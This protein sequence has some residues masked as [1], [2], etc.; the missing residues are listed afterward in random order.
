MRT[1]TFYF[2]DKKSP[3][4]NQ[5]LDII[6]DAKNFGFSTIKL[7]TQNN[8]FN[9]REMDFLSQIEG[10][11]YFLELV[12]PDHFEF[13]KHID[14]IKKYNLIN[15]FFEYF[16]VGDDGSFVDRINQRKKILFDIGAKIGILYTIT[17]QNISKA[18][19][20]TKI[21]KKSNPNFISFREKIMTE[22]N[23]NCGLIVGIDDLKRFLPVVKNALKSPNLRME[24]NYQEN[25]FYDFISGKELIIES[26]GD[27]RVFPFS[28]AV[29]TA[30]IFVDNFE[31]I[32]DRL[33][34]AYNLLIKEALTDNKFPNWNWYASKYFL[35]R[36]S[37]A[38][39]NNK[40]EW[41]DIENIILPMA[42]N[43]LLTRNCNLQCDFCEFECGEDK[44]EFLDI[45]ILEKLLTDGKKLGISSVVFD[46]GEPLVYPEIRK[47]LDL[48]R[49]LDYELVMLTNGWY[50]KEFEKLLKKCKINDLIFNLNGATAS[51]HDKIV[52]KDG[53]YEK[54]IQSIKQ[55]KVQGFPVSIL[56]LLHPLNLNELDQF[57]NL[58]EKLKVNCVRIEGVRA[59]GRAA[60][61]QYKIPLNK[62]AEIEKTYK[63]H[64][65]FLNKV[66]SNLYLPSASR[67]LSC[68]YLESKYL[69]VDWNGKLNIC[70][71]TPT[72][73]I[74]FPSLKDYSLI[75]A[76]I[77]LNKM[78][79]KFKTDRNAE[80]MQWRLELGGISCEYCKYK[81]ERNNC[82]T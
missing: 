76:I 60:N 32:L 73:N 19:E 53:A 18:I 23:I 5:F 42:F 78:N 47:A 28:S 75:D 30:N 79:K 39:I 10:S 55:A 64:H 29:E 43:V 65:D 52:G 48:V 26:D 35:H 70:S 56:F 63:N 24:S 34:I 9:E 11:D 82:L 4:S 80:F 61:G 71:M 58:A 22:E 57:L 17:P 20:I 77:Y 31:E 54:V 38:K 59:L 27:V 66:S 3:K 46:G 25:V 37:R 68:K 62:K 14:I 16:D 13:E 49:E 74:S 50:Y 1:L 45:N 44:K 33:N 81:L 7:I 40:L 8:K 36:L 67:S 41:H 12:L 69:A 2:D 72:L 6:N 21:F 15:V 51:V